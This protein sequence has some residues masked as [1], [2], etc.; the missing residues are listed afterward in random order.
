MLVFFLPMENHP[1]LSILHT[2]IELE[3]KEQLN[4]YQFNEQHN[5]R[6]LKAEGLAIHPI[7]ITKKS[8]G[9][10]DYPELSFRI[11]FPSE[12]THFRDGMAIECFC[13]GEEPIKGVLL[14]LNG[15]QGEF[16]LFAPDFP[17]WIEDDAV[18][19]KLSP[20]T[21]TTSLMKK[22][23][24]N[25][26]LNQKSKELFSQIHD[27]TKVEGHLIPEVKLL[28]DYF[29]EKLNESQKRSVAGIIQNENI[30]IVHGPPG[31]G[32]TTTLLE[33]I[34]QLVKKG[35]RILVAA[36]SNAAVDHI[37]EG[38]IDTSINFMRIGHNVKVNAK[39]FPFTS[40]GKLKDSKEE[41]EIKK[42]KIRAEEL[43]K[44]ALQ[45]KRKFGK[46][47]R[48]QRN[49]LF[50]EVKNLR[51]EIRKIQDYNEEQLFEKAQVVFGT[52]I[53]LTDGRLKN[54]EFQTLIIDE[55]GQCL[56][57]LAW[58]IFPFA[59]KIVLA[60]DH[61]QLPP[62]VLSDKASKMGFNQSIL[63]VSFTKFPN[64]FLLDTQYRMRKSI[65][66]FSSDH[67]YDG[68]LKT[69]ESLNDIGIHFTFFDTAGAGFEEE[70]GK[71]GGSLMNQ[72][73]LTVM[74]QI[75]EKEQLDLA[76]TAVIS[77]YAG[78]VALVQESLPKELRVS[79]IDRFQGQEKEN[80]LISLVRSN[81]EGIIGFLKDYRRMNV[82]M[83]R[84]KEKLFV[85][86]DSSTLAK[87]PY[88]SSLL[89]YAKKINAY[90]SVWEIM[91]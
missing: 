18:G 70:S 33:S 82:A 69:V 7:R 41:K 55:A 24:E 67:F 64:V 14:S 54:L 44:M 61:L 80:I 53:G 32:K 40:E 48:E 39:I 72:G 3:E 37:A 35:E 42:L 84:A 59:D 63:E 52:P 51:Q 47:E 26:T 34:R 2:C 79:T 71:D 29:N 17:E 6:S 65:A 43:R 21:R 23:L 20:D 28:D 27:E 57:P 60:G 38:L 9:Y 83:T 12:T 56:E 66:Q 58:C 87:D 86:G 10:A 75:I 8:F 19:L 1:H 36:P 45:Y 74:Q 13:Q 73:E 50:R 4:R 22:A 76:C 81:E 91:Y 88:F 62:T 90:K 5:L 11:P 15:K 46:D 16:R 31:T 30:L 78:Q 49:L 25:I 77:P 85:I 89:D 68:R